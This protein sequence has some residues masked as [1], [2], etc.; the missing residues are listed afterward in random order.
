MR[1][2]FLSLSTDM[3]NLPL[4]HPSELLRTLIQCDGS[5]LVELVLRFLIFKY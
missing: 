3:S 5:A 4:T 1:G 2:P